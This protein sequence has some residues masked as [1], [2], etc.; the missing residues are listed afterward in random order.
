MASNLSAEQTGTLPYLDSFFFGEDG[1]KVN[2]REQ[3]H[4][5]DMQGTTSMEKSESNLARK[6][7]AYEVAILVPIEVP[8]V[9]K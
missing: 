4:S 3:F 6:R 2:T 9:C 1:E 7:L 8:C 5:S